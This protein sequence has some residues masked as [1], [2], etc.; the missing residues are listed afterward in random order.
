MKQSRCPTAIR[1]AA[2]E[3]LATRELVR[4]GL[5]QVAAGTPSIPAD[6]VREWLAAEDDR[7]F[8]DCRKSPATR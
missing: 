4:E 6:A 8:P 2:E 5:R 3:R 1:A 7:P